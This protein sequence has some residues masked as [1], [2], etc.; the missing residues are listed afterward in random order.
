[1]KSTIF[2]SIIS[3]ILLIIAI[4]L[5]LVIGKD[6]RESQNDIKILT[7]QVEK[8]KLDIVKLK[9]GK[10]EVRVH[11]IR[12]YGFKRVASEDIAS[13]FKKIEL[14][15]NATKEHTE[16]YIDA[17]LDATKTQNAFAA[18]DLQV[19]LLQK[20]DY[21]YLPLLISR[22]T[23]KNGP[24]NFHLSL[25]AVALVKNTDKKF[26]LKLLPH[27]PVLI[28]VVVKFNWQNDARE[29]IFKKLKNNNYLPKNWIV[30]AG[31]L[32]KPDDY[33]ILI[34]YFIRSADKLNIYNSIKDLPGIKLEDAV[35]MTWMAKS[36]SNNY[37][38]KQLALVAADFGHLDALETVIELRNDSNRYYH[39]IAY[40]KILALTGYRG[41]YLNMKKWFTDNK[42]RLVFD[43]KSQQYLEQ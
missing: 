10:K 17:I 26:I 5:F 12:R 36:N 14:P 24:D 4:G 37:G 15:L 40:D 43:K 19:E 42:N 35:A 11:E 28:D 18:N 21:K 34:G 39:R 23:D 13:K 1:M 38:K 8:L 31:Q 41:S 22:I 33:E 3:I 2:I 16:T 29:I 27:H 20:I 32:A 9:Q 6:R 25:A 30:C 7:A